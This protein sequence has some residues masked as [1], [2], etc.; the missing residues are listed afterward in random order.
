MYVD[1]QNL[2]FELHLIVITSQAAAYIHQLIFD[3]EWYQ[4]IQND[5]TYKMLTYTFY[6]TIPA[7]FFY[8]INR[9]TTYGV[10]NYFNTVILKYM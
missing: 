9:L 4:Y 8:S 3:I 10:K 5:H 2:L 6:L 7:C 1:V